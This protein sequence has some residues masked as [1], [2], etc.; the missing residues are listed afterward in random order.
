MGVDADRSLRVSVGWPSTP[1]DVDAFAAAFPKVME[2]L[3]ALRGS[4]R[5]ERIERDEMGG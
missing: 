1:A 2:Q 4:N 3:R 5:N